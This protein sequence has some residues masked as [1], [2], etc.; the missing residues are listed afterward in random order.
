MRYANIQ[1]SLASGGLKWRTKAKKRRKASFVKGQIWTFVEQ[2]HQIE[3]APGWIAQS[4]VACRP[5]PK[6]DKAPMRLLFACGWYVCESLLFKLQKNK[7]SKWCT[8]KKGENRAQFV[9]CMLHCVHGRRKR[10]HGLPVQKNARHVL[11]QW[12]QRSTSCSIRR[13]C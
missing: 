9:P 4:N 11:R 12:R 8:N 1:G 2:A 10:F 5:P 7:L 13:L 6:A 3:F